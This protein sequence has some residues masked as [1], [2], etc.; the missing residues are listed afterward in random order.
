MKR[1]NYLLLKECLRSEVPYAALVLKP[2]SMLHVMEYMN[3]LHVHAALGYILVTTPLFPLYALSSA[4]A[5]VLNIC[6]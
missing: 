5:S 1:E 3:T 4:T 6:V 2:F